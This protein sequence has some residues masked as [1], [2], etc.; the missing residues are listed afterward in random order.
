MA[1][2]ETLYGGY[3]GTTDVHDKA[4]TVDGKEA[5]SHRTEI[6]VDDERVQVEGDVAEVTVID[7]GDGESYA[8]FIGVTPIGDQAL[9]RA[10]DETVASITVD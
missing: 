6:R 8:F 1:R 9:L 5:W 3:Q 10:M 2:A 7:T 4:T